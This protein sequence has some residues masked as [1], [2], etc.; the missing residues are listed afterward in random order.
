MA[1][2]SAGMA[3]KRGNMPIYDVTW[4]SEDGN[5][6]APLGPVCADSDK[7]ALQTAVEKFNE[8]EDDLLV[9]AQK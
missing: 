2:L 8:N 6:Y 1:S 5:E 3:R 7:E 9:E 4:V